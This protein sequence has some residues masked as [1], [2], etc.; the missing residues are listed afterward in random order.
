MADHDDS[1]YDGNCWDLCWLALQLFISNEAGLTPN[2]GL[3]LLQ[4]H[5]GRNLKDHVGDEENRKADI[6]FGVVDVSTL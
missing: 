1:P 4:K 6:I 2:R 3:E 5:I